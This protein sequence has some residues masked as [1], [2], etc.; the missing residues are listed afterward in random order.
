MP[1]AKPSADCYS[2]EATPRRHTLKKTRCCPMAMRPPTRRFDREELVAYIHGIDREGEVAHIVVHKRGNF[3]RFSGRLGDHRVTQSNS[4]DLDN[5]VH[6][7]ET[8]GVW[9]RPSAY[10]AHG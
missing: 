6:E 3:I 7:A 10:C 1:L 5:W 4:G 8:V 2:N 9:R